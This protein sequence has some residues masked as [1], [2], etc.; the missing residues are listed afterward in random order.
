MSRKHLTSKQHAFLQFLAEHVRKQK[1]W[2]TYREIVDYFGYRSPNS[3]T[4]NLQALAKK[5]YLSRDHNG[6]RLVGQRGGV[7]PAGFPIQG[8]IEGGT[9][10]ISLTIDK[11]TLRDL[12]PGLDKT[13]AVRIDGQEVRGIDRIDGGYLL[14]QDGEIGDGHLSAVLHDGAVALGRVYRDEDR[15]RL[16]HLDGT[17][18]GIA[19]DAPGFQLLGRYAGHINQRGI[20]RAPS[21][22]YAEHALDDVVLATT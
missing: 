7:Q 20:A 6:Y 5:G 14:L 13:F 18:A 15:L 11:L 12:F 3:V 21:Q 22:D 16:E 9:F 8:T 4:Q 10:E 19:A 17:E 2:P 1:V